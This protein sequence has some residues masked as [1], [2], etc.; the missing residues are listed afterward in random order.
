[1]L[2]QE[3][4]AQPD[5]NDVDI[6]V[7]RKPAMAV[8]QWRQTWGSLGDFERQVDRLLES[9]RFPFP[10]VRLD[11]P[12]P[13]VNVYELNDEFLITAELPGVAPESL[14]LTVSGG[15]LTLKGERSGPAGISDDRFRR[16]ERVWG[17]WQRSLS[18]PERVAEERVSA[19]F[20]EGILKIR[21]PKAVEIKPRHIPVSGA[22]G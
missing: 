2:P 16:H 10:G 9:I 20:N 11:R 21:L 17:A 15:I 7:E 18:I 1:L 3:N 8:F 6:S 22:N 14:E 19:E 13:P 5:K 4:P 12:Y